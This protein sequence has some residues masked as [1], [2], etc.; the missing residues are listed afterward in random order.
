LSP[1]EVRRT[2]GIN[3][4]LLPERREIEN[5]SRTSEETTT[6]LPTVLPVVEIV[7]ADLPL[8]LCQTRDTALPLLLRILTETTLPLPRIVTMDLLP[9]ELTDR[10][11]P[12]VLLPVD[13]LHPRMATIIELRYLLQ[14]L[15]LTITKT[16]TNKDLLL[17]TRTHLL[18]PNKLNPNQQVME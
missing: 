14:Y 4:G 6:L 13:L 3:R 1:P 7:M 5:V 8:L 2:T 12:P 11:L 10:C 17:R 16:L 18:L 9:Q 15:L